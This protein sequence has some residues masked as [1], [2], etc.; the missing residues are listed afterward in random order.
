MSTLISPNMSLPV[1]GVGT[2]NGPD[3]AYDINNCFTL[4]DQHDHSAGKGV[5]VTPAGLN[6]N[7]TLNFQNNQASNLS[8]LT[9]ILQ[10]S[11]S[12][13]S[14]SL[15]V[16]PGSE[17]PALNDLWYCDGTNPPFKITSG[18]AVYAPTAT[19]SGINFSGSSFAFTQDQAIVS[20][21][22]T[23]ANLKAGS[24]VIQPNT[25]ATSYGTTIAPYS[26]IASAWTLTLPAD[27]TSAGGSNFLLMDTSGNI[28]GGALVD[29]SSIQY[30]SH[31][32]SV[33]PGGITAAMLANQ[34]LQQVVEFTVNGSWTVPT[35]VTQAYV[36][37]YGG[38]GGGGG[39]A[40]NGVNAA[41][42]GGG[43]GGG[44]CT[45]QLITVIPGESLTVVVG[46]GGAVGVGGNPTG[47]SGGNGNITTLSRSG[48]TLV[49]AVGGIGGGGAN[50][51]T[52]TAGAGGQ[53]IDTTSMFTF[54]RAAGGAG[55]A[56]AN[57]GAAGAVS[58]FAPNSTAA[59]G[60]TA[61]AYGGGGGGGSGYTIGGAGGS[62]SSSGNSGTA[63]A[64]NSGGGGGGGSA[65][66][67]G[68]KN[69]GAGGRGVMFIYWV[70]P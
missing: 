50:S 35:N 25:A 5:Q 21:P 40:W 33:K 59:G 34:A 13:T 61:A 53:G 54:F 60:G 20:A 65:Y 48:T 22:T 2:E 37:A 8:A 70:A 27:P 39:G 30:T 67:G 69:G 32:L 44:G 1:P 18:G 19:I 3:Y 38:G 26:G 58:L 15:S 6:I 24:I 12:S 62:G 7:A 46:T 52:S 11:A 57:G 42:G 47:T 63:A 41:C 9:F 14:S 28:S 31:Q 16:A 51:S 55:G 29:N 36:V 23:P 66:S 56:G 64:A 45:Q 43:G 68:G 49:Y 4:L 17:T 10:G